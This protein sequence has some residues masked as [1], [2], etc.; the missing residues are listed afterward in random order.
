MLP[1][2]PLSAFGRQMTLHELADVS[3]RLERYDGRD[4]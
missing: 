2:I 3:E 1:G 4:F